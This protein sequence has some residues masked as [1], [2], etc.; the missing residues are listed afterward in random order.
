MNNKQSSSTFNQY[1]N[2]SPYNNQ[3]QPVNNPYQPSNN[4]QGGQNGGN[5]FA[6]IIKGGGLNHVN[7]LNQ[8]QNNNQGQNSSQQSL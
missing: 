6:D 3:Y 8:N 7:N 1:S 4:V 2:Q 5:L